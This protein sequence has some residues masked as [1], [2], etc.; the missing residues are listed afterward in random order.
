MLVE[1]EITGTDMAPRIDAAT[2]NGA[3]LTEEL[4]RIEARLRQA[5]V[6]RDE[7]ARL[8]SDAER[9]RAAIRSVRDTREEAQATLAT[10]PLTFEYGSGDLIPGKSDEWTLAEAATEAGENFLH[11]LAIILILLVTLLPWA[12]LALAGWLLVRWVRR[13]GWLG[14]TAGAGA[15]SRPEE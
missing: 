7:R 3:E 11:A 4:D 6:G 5:D 9:I 13:R 15:I 1:S 2:R 12:L 8:V 10:T 14:A